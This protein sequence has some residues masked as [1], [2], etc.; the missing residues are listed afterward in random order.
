MAYCQNLCKKEQLPGKLKKKTRFL[1]Y[2]LIPQYLYQNHDFFRNVGKILCF[3]N[4]LDEIKCEMIK[5]LQEM[6]KK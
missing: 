1:S 3:L 2:F 5:N 6:A 4:G